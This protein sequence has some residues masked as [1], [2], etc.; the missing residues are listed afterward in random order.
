MTAIYE[1]ADAGARYAWL[2][3]RV[4]VSAAQAGLVLLQPLV[5]DVHR[6]GLPSSAFTHDQKA[7]TAA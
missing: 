5:Q 6:G 7:R 4:I 1:A 3:M 2:P